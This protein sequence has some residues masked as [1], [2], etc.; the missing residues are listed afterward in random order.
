[1]RADQED[2]EMPILVKQ[3]THD[4]RDALLRAEFLNQ[5]AIF[6]G[7]GHHDLRILWKS[8]RTNVTAPHG[9]S[10]ASAK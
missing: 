3:S 2:A 7:L 6:S 9:V 4:D 5:A 8:E 1:M 10:A